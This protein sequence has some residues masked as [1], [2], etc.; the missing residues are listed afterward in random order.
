MSAYP[1]HDADTDADGI[2]DFKDLD[3]DNDGIADLVE[4]STLILDTDADQLPDYRDLDSDQDGIADTIEARPT[5]GYVANDGDISND[6]ADGD[7]IIALFD[8]NDAG[9]GDFG[10]TYANFNAPV[11]TDQDSRDGR[12]SRDRCRCP[13][14]I[15][16]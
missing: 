14:R 5:A 7:G 3:S 13:L 16:R 11:D 9:S 2:P 12:G 10:G 8:D 15:L 6:D 1:H 4:S